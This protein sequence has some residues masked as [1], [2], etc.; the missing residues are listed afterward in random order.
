MLFYYPIL[1]F[2]APLLSAIIN[3]L[4]GKTLGKNVFKLGLFFHVISV[5]VALQIFYKIVVVGPETIDLSGFIAPGSGFFEFVFYIDRLAAV[6]MLLI[7]LITATI[8]IFSMSYMRE[9]PDYPK[10]NVLLSLTTFILFC[11]VSSSNLLMIFI[12][13]QLISF[14]LYLLSYQYTNYPTMMGSFKTF[15]VLRFGDITFL[16]GIALAYNIYGTL[17][18]K[19][20]F[21]QVPSIITTFSFG[22]GLEISA[23]TAITLLIFIGAMSKSAQF[24][25]HIWVRDALYA[26]TPMHALLHA[27]IINAGG[28]LINRLAP[29]YGSSS[30]T[31]HIVLIVG[32][33]T[34]IVGSMTMLAQNN[35]KRTLGYS[36]IGQMGFMILECGIG[37]FALAIFHLIAH[38]LF[39]ATIFLN[40][41]NIIHKARLEP[42]LPYPAKEKASDEGSE[43]LGFSLLTWVTGFALSLVLPLIILL[44]AHGT[45]QIS[46]VDSQ[47]TLVFLFFSWVTSSQAIMA[48]YKAQ[49][50]TSFNIS[51]KTSLIMFL[52]LVVIVFAYLFAVESFTYFLYPDHDE[53]ALYFQAAA[54]PPFIFDVLIVTTLVFVIT[55]WALNYQRAHGKKTSLPLWIREFTAWLYIFIV[56]KFHIDNIYTWL[57]D[58]II[59][60]A[61]ILEKRYLRYLP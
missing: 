6:M 50:D 4:L 44:L 53:V 61:H 36:T 15:M 41:G 60:F 9:E 23:N 12:F 13:W 42:K 10:F 19:E 59:R 25:L 30:A 22:P 28:F 18:L 29:L 58:K 48:I 2:A 40:C 31:L 46:L 45:L 21:A 35:I 16:A 56:N 57:H 52:T 55:K 26:P 37:A 54:L 1:I 43:A 27:G 14:M 32:L 38:G 3:G 49:T 33:L 39:K 34:V 17:E 24:P 47:G 7:A 8:Y 20:I 5:V 11:L 51:I